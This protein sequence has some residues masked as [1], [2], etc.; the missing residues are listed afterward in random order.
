MKRIAALLLATLAGSDLWSQAATDDLVTSEITSDAS[1]YD[2]KANSLHYWGRVHLNSPGTLDLRCEDFQIQLS[3][4]NKLDQIVASTNVVLLLVQ[5]ATAGR[6][7]LT[8]TAFAHQ[9]I[10]DGTSN[11]VTLA[12]SP[13]GVQPRFEGPDLVAEAD[14]IIYNRSSERFELKGNHRTRFKP[15]KLPKGGF[16]APNNAASPAAK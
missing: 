13:A 12:K 14:V 2:Q 9:A 10:F 15:G 4:G 8:N 16:F 11:L 5:P 6:P 3:T 7:A 1:V